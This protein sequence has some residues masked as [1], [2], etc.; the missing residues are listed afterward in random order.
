MP[1]A[2]SQNT[3]QKLSEQLEVIYH[4]V[5]AQE[6][7]HS[8]LLEGLHPNW[9][10]SGRNLLHYLAMRTFDLRTL[11]DQLS[12]LSISSLRYSESYT[13]ANLSRVLYLLKLLQQESCVLRAEDTKIDF[14]TSKELLQKQADR[15]FGTRTAHQDNRI[16]V[17]LPEKA[18]TDYQFVKSLL[19]AGMDCARINCSHHTPQQWQQMADHVRRAELEVG[20]KCSIYVDLAGPKIRTEEIP[21]GKKYHRFSVGN[22][23]VIGRKLKH[24]KGHKEKGYSI[25]LP[26]VLDDVQAGQ[27]I[28]FNDGKLGGK[29]LEVHNHHLQVELT[30]TEKEKKKLKIDKGINLPETEL[31]LPALT[32]ADEEALDFVADRADIVGYSFVRTVEDIALLQDKL[33]ERGLEDLGVVLKIETRQA[34][35]CFP[36]LLFQLMKSRRAGIMVARGDLAVEIGFER[37]AEVQEELLWLCEAAH[38]PCIWA[39]QVLR[40][41]TKKGIATRAEIT[42]AAMSVRAE[43]VM[44]NTGDYLVKAIETLEDILNRMQDHQVKKNTIMRPLQVARDFANR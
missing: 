42:D 22:K 29:I 8:E 25:S 14:Y 20:Y 12:A 6:E 11:H 18:A 15:L 4:Q 44:L 7:K 33:K 32:K 24:I 9:Q 39:T 28:W 19:A 35:D 21:E 23:L 10:T 36:D 17:T 3:L 30:Y 34:F 27:P 16:M 43:C 31:N 40:N 26:Q 41:L 13:L 5:K 2:Y 38:M 1:E 37:I